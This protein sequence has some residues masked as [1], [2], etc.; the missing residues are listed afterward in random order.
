MIMKL[1]GQKLTSW[2]YVGCRVSPSG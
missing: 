2:M 1:L